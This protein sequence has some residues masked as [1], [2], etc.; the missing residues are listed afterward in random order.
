MVR[1]AGF[2]IPLNEMGAFDL[3]A[4]QCLWAIGLWMGTGSPNGF[5]KVLISKVCVIAALLVAATFFLL[6]H[7]LLH[8]QF[9]G[10]LWGGLI[11]KWHLGALRL[12][13]FSAF[14][15]LFAVSRS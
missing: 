7:S 3:L 4:W 5:F 9:H 6:R 11:D 15:I 12:L 13:D 8:V 10:A 14:A 2:Q 1:S